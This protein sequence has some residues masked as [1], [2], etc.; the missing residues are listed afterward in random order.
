MKVLLNNPVNEINIKGSRFIA[1]VFTVTTQAEAREKLHEQKVKYSDA[2]HVCHCFISGLKAEACGM[3]DDGEPSGTAG[4]PMLDV[5]KGSGITNILVTVTR[6][7]GGTLLG[8]G[9]LVKAYGDSVKEV[10]ALCETEEY[11]ERSEFS[12]ECDWGIYETIKRKI[13]VFHISDLTE[14]F[15]TGVR[16][17]GKIHASEL[18][19]MKEMIKNLSKGKIICI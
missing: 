13:E 9:G 1:E 4:R 6:Y 12:F 19:D 11:I 10:L 7:F 18:D 5:L 15:A 8:T 17:S 16:L 3:S 14:E 2:T